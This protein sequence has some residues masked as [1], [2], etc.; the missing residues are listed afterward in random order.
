MVAERTGRKVHIFREGKQ[1]RVLVCVARVPNSALRCSYLKYKHLIL[2]T[3]SKVYYVGALFEG[4]KKN[5]SE[6]HE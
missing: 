3:I 5:V 6:V 2:K 1:L 4:K